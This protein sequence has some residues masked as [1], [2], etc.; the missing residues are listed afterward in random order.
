MRRVPLPFS[1]RGSQMLNFAGICRNLQKIAVAFTLAV[2]GSKKDREKQKRS[3]VGFGWVEKEVYR[4]EGNPLESPYKG[5]GGS[6]ILT[7]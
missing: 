3:S 6:H 1:V 2:S 4:G 5:V 7:P